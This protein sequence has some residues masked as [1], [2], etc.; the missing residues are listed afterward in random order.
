MAIDYSAYLSDDVKRSILKQREQ[1][2]VLEA[3]Q[4]S[5]NKE[6]ALVNG[7]QDEIVN[8]SDEALVS[9]EAALAFNSAELAKLPAEASPVV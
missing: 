9:L 2:F 7:G 3:W 4:H 5:L 8:K 1:Q 6:A